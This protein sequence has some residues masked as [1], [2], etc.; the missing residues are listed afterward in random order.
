MKKLALLSAAVLVILG[1]ATDGA[2]DKGKKETLN[3][4]YTWVGDGSRGSLEAIF[5]PAADGE[6]KVAFHFVFSGR[7]HTFKGTA[8]GSLTDGALEGTVFNENRR[9]TFTFEGAFEDGTFEG[10]HAEIRRGRASQI[11]T[12]TLER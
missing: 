7:P 10:T 1:I 2:A 11:G 5:T 3:G 12:L 8:T 9:R 6:W 4:A